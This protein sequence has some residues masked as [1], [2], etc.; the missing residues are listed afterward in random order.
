[1]SYIF[2]VYG[3]GVSGIIEVSA[4]DSED[5]INK[6]NNLGLKFK[7]M[8]NSLLIYKIQYSIVNTKK[9]KL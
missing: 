8:R 5:A 9:W 3:N 6:V 4:K 7:S 2:D 1:M